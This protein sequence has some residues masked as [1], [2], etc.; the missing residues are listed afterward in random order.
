MKTKHKIRQCESRQPFST[1]RK[2][3]LRRKSEGE[4]GV[5]QPP[6]VR[7]K[8]VTRGGSLPVFCFGF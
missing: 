2:D 3:R 5:V 6:V 4:G 8:Q 1:T 7:G